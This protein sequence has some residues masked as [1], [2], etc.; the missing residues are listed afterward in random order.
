VRKREI[1][2]DTERERE[3]SEREREREENGTY[4]EVKERISER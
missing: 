2:S 1:G 3:M 4:M